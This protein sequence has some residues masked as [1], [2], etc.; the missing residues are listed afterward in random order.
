MGDIK[1]SVIVPVYKV[2]KFIE[3]CAESLL[4]QTLKGVEYIFVNDA[5][6]DNSIAKLEEILKKYP[7]RKE[8]VKILH[9][10]SNRGLPTARNTGL[11]Q[12]TGEY[13]FHC[14]SDDYVDS[15]MLETMYSTAINDDL[16]IAWC[17]WYLSF[18]RKERYM[19]QPSY[20]TPLEAL[21]G[22]M[23][24]AMKFNVWNKIA[25]RSLYT[26]NQI[27]FPD[28]NGMGEDMTMMMLFAYAQR[29]KYIPE[30]FYHYVKTNVNAFSCTYSDQHLLELSSNVSRIENFIRQRYGK[31]LD[32]EISYMKLEAKFPFLLS[33][34][35]TTV[36][37]WK[38]W[39]PEA[40]DE[41]KTNHFIS[42]R[43]RNLQLLA[44][45][46]Q[47]WIIGLYKCALNIYYSIIYKQ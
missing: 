39:Y 11:A 46:N 37:L 9:H 27:S 34:D 4:N 44:A 13:I 23:S 31:S 33:K 17:D 1:V 12:A 28:G 42:S 18:D 15:K 24:G 36:K 41:I 22:M 47:F 14:D 43:N 2:E 19:K 29:V 25:K 45:R 20:N 21:K 30:A 38:L 10:E 5:T 35:N 16:D 6:P 3:R 32:K 7:E 26:E 40:N 8:A